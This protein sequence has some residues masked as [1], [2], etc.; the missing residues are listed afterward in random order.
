MPRGKRTVFGMYCTETGDRIGSIR[1]HR[2]NSKGKSWKD[3][4]LEKF[5]RRVRRR[6]PVK[7]KEEKH[8]SN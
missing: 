6:V 8:S 4:K 5:S 7:L 3:L 2:Q 1:L